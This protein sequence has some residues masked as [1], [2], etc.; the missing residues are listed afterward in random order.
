MG[1]PQILARG[2]V[3]HGVRPPS[4]PPAIVTVSPASFSTEA[5]AAVQLTVSVTNGAGSTTWETSDP[6]I[7]TVSAS[8][9]VTG[10]GTGS[11]VIVARNSG[12]THYSIGTV[13]GEVEAPADPTDPLGA[14]VDL[15]GKPGD[16][17][18]VL[19]W[20]PVPGAESHQPQY[21]QG[22]GSWVSFGSVLEATADGV[23]V[24]GLDTVEYQFRV[25]AYRGTE[26]TQS[27]VVSATPLAAVS[28]GDPATLLHGVMSP[29]TSDGVR[30][31]FK[32]GQDADGVRLA[33]STDP[34]LQTHVQFTA[35]QDLN[36]ANYHTYDVTLSGLQPDT[37]YT[38]APYAG[39]EFVSRNGIYGRFRTAPLGP[40]S[41]SVAFSNC[42]Q[43]SGSAPRD[44]TVWDHIREQRPAVFAH[45]DDFHYGDLV[46]ADVATRV[47]YDENQ[48]AQPR[49]G[50]C[51]MQVPL[52]RGMGDHDFCGNDSY[53]GR[54]TPAPGRFAAAAAY[55]VTMPNPPL[56]HAEGMYFGWTHGRVRFLKLDGRFFRDSRWYTGAGKTML[57][58][59]QKAWF[60]A[61]LDAAAAAISAGT[62]GL[63][64]VLGDVP[65]TGAD[66]G[67][68]DHWAGYISERNELG[69]YIEQA[70][71]TGNLY[72]LVGDMHR[73]GFDSGANTR[74]SSTNSGLPAFP[75]ACGGSLGNA[76]G[77]IKG[78]WTNV[79][80]SNG[81]NRVGFLHIEDDGGEEITVTT[82]LR[83]I[84]SSGTAFTENLGGPFVNTFACQPLSDSGTTPGA[85]DLPADAASL[86]ASATLFSD[87]SFNSLD[88]TD[89]LGRSWSDSNGFGTT[90]PNSTISVV[91]GAGRITLPVGYPG[92]GTTSH[93]ARADL[94]GW[95][96]RNSGIVALKYRTRYSS[97]W[98]N[99]DGANV[100]KT[101][102]MGHTV[103]PLTIGNGYSNLT[104]RLGLQ[105]GENYNANYN[106][107]D[108]QVFPTL[109]QATLRRDD[110][111]EVLIVV[112]IGTPGAFNGKLH[113]WMRHPSDQ[114]PI[115]VKTHQFV[116]RRILSATGI[117]SVMDWFSWRPIYGGQNGSRR[118][119]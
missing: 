12:V 58:I 50:N 21:R 29:P 38:W 11:V 57:G 8:G 87:R 39:G 64:V 84:N 1:I 30:I 56:P 53:G 83:I 16:G 109:A 76:Q 115:W 73:Q 92:T 60:K 105:G 2:Q 20:T 96:S 13:T 24:S 52:V 79:E 18:V 66:D 85:S 78:A 111:T 22:A 75:S 45:L 103:I 32:S 95:P 67:D 48:M 101:W 106:S 97:N 81:Q 23:V 72:W 59:A 15:V 119:R 42:N 36:S 80:G 82:S 107:A 35:P 31:K 17:L 47:L 99:H 113:C 108:N 46:D 10:V 65:W 118:Y 27:N 91:D 116:N 49:Q 102:Y 55:R 69:Q 34:T 33:Y 94:L 89:N 68:E 51:Y 25:L 62:L 41:F 7:A 77:E 90:F 28:T 6:A 104:M 110:W 40:A 19:E 5:G 26:S 88:E 9:L 98:Y 63:V 86:L 112:E 70:G 100:S 4:S 37:E 54:N 14:I 114:N 43:Y 44:L 117:Y 61:E 71:L 93:L 3:R 74:F